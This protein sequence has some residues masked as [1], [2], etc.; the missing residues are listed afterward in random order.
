M[1]DQSNNSNISDVDKDLE[2]RIVFF[3]AEK[4]LKKNAAAYDSILNQFPELKSMSPDRNY[5]I[6][7]IKRVNDMRQKINKNLKAVGSRKFS[8]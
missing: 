1:S 6:M 4:N 3:I 2:K 5:L 8:S 7:L